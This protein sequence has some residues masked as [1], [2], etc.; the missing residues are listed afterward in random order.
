[1]ATPGALAADDAGLDRPGR[2]ASLGAADLWLLG[3]GDSV[4]TE[5]TIYGLIVF[6]SSI[7]ID[8]CNVL[9][10]GCPFR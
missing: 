5:A 1:M 10:F 7:Y 9:G 3:R 6:D 8:T 2:S 4:D